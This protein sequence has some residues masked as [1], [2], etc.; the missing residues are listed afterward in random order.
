MCRRGGS[1][2]FSLVDEA[3][4]VVHTGFGPASD[5]LAPVRHVPGCGKALAEGVKSGR[6]RLHD[7]LGRPVNRLDA[8]RIVNS[9]NG[10]YQRKGRSQ[11]RRTAIYR[12]GGV[13]YFL[14]L[15]GAA[16]FLGMTLSDLAW[17][18]HRLDDCYI[19]HDTSNR[20]GRATVRLK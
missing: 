7:I 13:R 15:T 9:L 3:G 14:T 2:V 17:Q 4:A 20:M 10:P 16:A 19:F 11:A 18:V 1:T 12:R 6:L 8:A 5:P